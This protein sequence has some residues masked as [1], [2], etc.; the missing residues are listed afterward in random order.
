MSVLVDTSVWSMAFRRGSGVEVEEL[1]RLVR[2][3]SAKII[4]AVRQEALQGFRRL[5]DFELV[6]SRLSS[7]DD[8]PVSRGDYERAAEYFNL[9]R[10]KGVQGSNTDFLLCSVAH[11]RKMAIFTTDRDFGLFARHLPVRLHLS[12]DANGRRP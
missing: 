12:D 6:R 11:A 8:V 2:S 4:G 9:C 3:G 10:S 5:Q 7:F 1:N